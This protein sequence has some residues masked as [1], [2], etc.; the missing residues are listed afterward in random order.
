MKKNETSTKDGININEVFELL[1]KEIISDT[2][3]LQAKNNKSSSQILKKKN[4]VVKKKIFL[5]VKWIIFNFQFV[6]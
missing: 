4:T 1:A 3:K 2:E 5:N 6:N